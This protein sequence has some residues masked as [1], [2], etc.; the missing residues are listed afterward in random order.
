MPFKIQYKQF[1]Y[2]QFFEAKP[3]SWVKIGSNWWKHLFFFHF[4]FKKYIFCGNLSNLSG[5]KSEWTAG[6]TNVL[7]LLACNHL[8]GT[9]YLNFISRILECSRN[10]NSAACSFYDFETA[11]SGDELLMLIPPSTGRITPVTK[12]ALSWAKKAIA[13]THSSDSPTRPMGWTV[14]M[15]FSKLWYFSPF[16]SIPR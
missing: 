15:V 9:C 14:A 10:T 1:K 16:R 8:V 7:I 5:K 2:Q 11:C 3:K 13:L 4:F 6:P 12:A